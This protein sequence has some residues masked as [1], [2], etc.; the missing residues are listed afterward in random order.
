MCLG[1]IKAVPPCL[2]PVRLWEPS[3]QWDREEEGGLIRGS[4]SRRASI[5]EERLVEELLPKSD[6]VVRWFRLGGP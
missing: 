3:A 5:G 1:G 6:T 2:E 4:K